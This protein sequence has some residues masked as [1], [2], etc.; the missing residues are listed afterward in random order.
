MKVELELKPDVIFFH[1]G[2][3]ES[4]LEIVKFSK[5]N[6]DQD[7]D[8]Y[9]DSK[10]RN[11]RIAENRRVVATPGQFLVWRA[12]GGASHDTFFIPE[13]SLWA[14]ARYIFPWDFVIP[15]IYVE[16]EDQ[17]RIYN[18]TLKDSEYEALMALPQNQL[19]ESLKRIQNGLQRRPEKATNT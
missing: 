3:K 9:F 11:W 17:E 8:I 12:A 19:G 18:I 14:T 6:F 5:E 13:N 1:D 16:P 4:G 7:W 10:A 15:P 2:S